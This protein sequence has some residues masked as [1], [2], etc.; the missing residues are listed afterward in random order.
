MDYVAGIFRNVCDHVDDN[1]V[2]CGKVFE[3][4]SSMNRHKQIHIRDAQR[5]MAPMEEDQCLETHHTVQ[6]WERVDKVVW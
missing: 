2:M 6:S 5:D 4:A 3:E 1:G